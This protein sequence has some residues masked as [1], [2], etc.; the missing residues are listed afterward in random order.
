MDLEKFFKIQ[1]YAGRLK[2]LP[3][4]GWIFRGVDNPESI[5]DHSFRVNLITYLLCLENPEVDFERAL[6]LA[7]FHDLG[8]SILTDIPKETMDLLS[9]ELKLESEI[10]SME[11]IAG[12]EDEITGFIR[13]YNE[14]KTRESEI[15]YAADKLEMLFQGLEYLRNGYSGVEEFFKNLD[16]LKKLQV[17]GLPEIISEIETEYE[18]IRK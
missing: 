16:Y 4:N 5:A 9:E 15:V 2:R 7:I 3:R 6:K 17:T 8:E 1:E 13:E 18:K 12:P 11:K 10:K 14:R